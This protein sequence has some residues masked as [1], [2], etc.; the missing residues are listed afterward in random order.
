MTEEE[1]RAAAY[2]EQARRREAYDQLR[3]LALRG[4]PIRRALLQAAWEPL[5]SFLAEKRYSTNG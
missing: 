1:I 5:S 2:R 3:L 4:S